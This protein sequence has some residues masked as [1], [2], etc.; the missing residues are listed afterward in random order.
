MKK[1]LLRIYFVLIIAILSINA[2]SAQTGKE[3][4]N[5][6][7]GKQ[8]PGLSFNY[9][10][11]L[12]SLNLNSPV[13]S[14]TQQ[15]LEHKI[16]GPIDVKMPFDFNMLW[17]FLITAFITAIVVV[18][19]TIASMYLVHKKTEETVSAIRSEILSRSI[20][21][22]INTLRS[23]LAEFLSFLRA[24]DFIF[25]N[26][27]GKDE[28]KNR[29]DKKKAVVKLAFHQAKIRLLL[30]PGDGGDL[31]NKLDTAFENARELEDGTDKHSKQIQDDINEIIRISQ[32]I[33]KGEWE[34]IK[35]LNKHED[36]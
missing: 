30:K 14:K 17:S 22:W 16:T 1:W 32:P 23:E 24:I 7:S 8:S 2:A 4:A 13:G 34:K 15:P 29:E 3:Q 19:S 6:D 10:D 27:G 21:E 5:K 18:G 25:N 12:F 36:N 11:D 28:K 35:D 31:I 20:Q 9:K 26:V 33:L